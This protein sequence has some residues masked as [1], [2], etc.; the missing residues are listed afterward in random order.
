MAR[1]GGGGAR[2]RHGHLRQIAV[3]QAGS[4]AVAPSRRAAALIRL[5]ETR[6]DT[7]GI[8][9]IFLSLAPVCAAHT[10]QTNLRRATRMHLSI[11]PW[12]LG[13]Q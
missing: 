13:F 7:W 11:V 4:S 12:R 5:P 6:P 1:A 2:Q 10:R 3:G 9:G 8:P